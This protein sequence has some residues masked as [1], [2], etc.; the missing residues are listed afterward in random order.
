MS[1]PSRVRAYG[2][3]MPLVDVFPFP[4]YKS[5]APTV[6]DKD[7]EIGQ[8]WVYKASAST[9]QIYEFGG[10]ASS[11][12]AI[13]CLTSPGASEVDVLGASSGDAS[14][15]PSAGMI[16]LDGTSG[17]ITATGS[18]SGASITFSLPSAITCPGSLTT[19]TTL[20]ATAG[21]ITA[22]NG[23]LAVGTAGNG[24]VIKE[25]SNARSGTATLSSGTIAVSNTSVTSNTRIHVSRQG[26]N[27]ST[28]LGS[29]TVVSNPSTGFTITSVSATTP[30]N[31]ITGD[32][33]IVH[34]FLVEHS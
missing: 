28:A 16:T 29:L 24:L 30:T 12:N 8:K 11:G 21:A 23:N 3:N 1:R 13:W 32:T 10:L 33:S 6:T 19:T 9:R 20:T 25:G 7:F 15:S 18:N 4:L 17:Q 26:I 27:S 14:V 5:S 22:T 31:T 2:Q 34:W